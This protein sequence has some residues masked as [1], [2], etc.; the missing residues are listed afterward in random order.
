MRETVVTLGE[1]RNLIGVLTEPDEISGRSDRP[2][3]L[4]TNAGTVHRVGPFRL[5]VL[6]ARKLANSGYTS[7]R[8][9]LTGIGDSDIDQNSLS[10]DEQMLKD[11]GAVIEF[12]QEARQIEQIVMIGLCTGADNA[13]KAAMAYRQ[14]VGAVHL[15]GYAYPTVK[16]L[17]N[18]LLP[19]VT[20]PKRLSRAI[21]SRLVNALSRFRPQAQGDPGSADDKPTNLFVWDLPDKGATTID[22][23]ELLDRNTSLCYIYTGGS[24]YTYNYLNQFRGAF[25]T[26]NFG[27]FLTECYFPEMDHTYVLKQDREKL[28]Q[29]ITKWLDR[30]YGDKAA[31]INVA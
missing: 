20:N 29:Y 6:L 15:D 24:S 19:V 27:D 12:L 31:A 25:K 14:I 23:R 3:I 13:H 28:I 2:A 21:I 16:F 4:L 10:Q 9:D 11:V 1:S 18:H 26:L 17:Y 5:N 7:I 30:T 22:L 8:F